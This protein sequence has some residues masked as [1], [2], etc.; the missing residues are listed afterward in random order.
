[1]WNQ[2]KKTFWGMQV[3]ILIITAMVFQTSHHLLIPAVAFFL[4]MQVG[5]AVGALWANRLRRKIQEAR[6]ARGLT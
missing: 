6:A 3:V 4:T 2:Y 5:G 1:M